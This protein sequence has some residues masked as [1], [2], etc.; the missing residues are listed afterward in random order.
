MNE[1]KK[2]M[3]RI[4]GTALARSILENARTRLKERDRKKNEKIYLLRQN[5]P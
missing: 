5:S 1:G 4:T 3:M 2:M